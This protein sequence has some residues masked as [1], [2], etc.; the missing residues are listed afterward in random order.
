M[1]SWV[2]PF[3]LE[4]YP[5]PPTVSRSTFA[6]EVSNPVFAAR[7]LASLFK[8]FD[9][10]SRRL[11]DVLG[12]VLGDLPIEAFQQI[13]VRGPFLFYDDGKTLAQ[14]QGILTPAFTVLIRISQRAADLPDSAL[15]GLLIH[16]LAHVYLRH[17]EVEKT[18]R[19][20]EIEA[21]ALARSWGFGD[22]I[23]AVRMAVSQ[24]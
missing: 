2:E 13:R 20:R 23:Q 7:R 4:H 12:F 1:K 22:E 17:F 24:I 9:F 14:V 6:D 18:S 19:E 21:D 5:I 8:I 15:R 11:T 3:L 10:S 16:E